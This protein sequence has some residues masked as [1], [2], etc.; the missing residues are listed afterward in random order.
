MAKTNPKPEDDLEKTVEMLKLSLRKIPH[1][2]RV[3]ISKLIEG[4]LSK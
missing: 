3:L 2:R 4:V 1:W